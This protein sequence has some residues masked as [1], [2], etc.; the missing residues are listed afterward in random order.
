MNRK[1]RNIILDKPIAFG[2]KAMEK[3]AAVYDQAKAILD[4][5]RGEADRRQLPHGRL[6]F[7]I[8]PFD[9]KY[10]YYVVEPI[11]KKQKP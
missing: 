5:A 8:G 7:Y 9:G 6:R 2:L 1:K 3:E 11:K 10:G 4:Q